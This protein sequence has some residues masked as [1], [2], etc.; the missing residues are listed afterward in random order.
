MLDVLP[1]LKAR[2]FLPGRSRGTSE[3]SCFP[4][5]CP[6]ERGSYAVSAFS[7]SLRPRARMFFAAFRSRSWTVPQAGQVHSRTFPDH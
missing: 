6:R 1:G 2:G 7:L 4:D 5:N 3:G